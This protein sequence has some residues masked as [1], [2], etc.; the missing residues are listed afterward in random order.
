[1]NSAQTNPM[2][3][4][5]PLLLL[6]G[7]RKRYAER[8]LLDIAHLSIAPAQA[9]VLTG[10]NGAGK[11]VLLRILAGLEAAQIDNAQFCGDDIRLQPYPPLLRAA[12]GYVH[13]HPVMF[14]GSVEYNIGY[15][16]RARGG[17][18][19]AAYAQA[20][21][22]ALAWAGLSALRQRA[23]ATLSGGEKQ[24][25][26]LARA[27]VLQPRLL[28]LDEPTAN[29]DGAAREQVLALI[30]D[31][32]REGRSLLMACHDRDVIHHHS[33]SHWKLRDGKLQIK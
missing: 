33:V 32:L 26:A 18:T 2:P 30:P 29:L 3:T 24:R 8:D 5:T 12:I 7:L 14:A 6:Q 15:G 22:Q 16:L 28:L 25:L 11:S 10:I 27:K 17:I 4:S 23:A 9:I 1:M 19:P 31:L 13:Q 21:T 20:V